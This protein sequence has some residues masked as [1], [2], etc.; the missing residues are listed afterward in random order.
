MQEIV[1][2][3]VSVCSQEKNKLP[4][5]QTKSTACIFCSPELSGLVEKRYASNARNKSRRSRGRGRGRGRGRAKPK[6]KMAQLAAYF[7]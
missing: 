6:D 4:D 1:F 7:V 2:I 3:R 5:G